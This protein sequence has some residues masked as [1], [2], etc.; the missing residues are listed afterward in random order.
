MIYNARSRSNDA[1]E[2]QKEKKTY[3]HAHFQHG[4]SKITR[5]NKMRS[6]K[7][8]FVKVLE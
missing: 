8:C 5:L 7:N 4:Q 1:T 3:F 6:L 2:S